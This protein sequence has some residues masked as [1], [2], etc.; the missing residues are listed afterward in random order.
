MHPVYALWPW[1]IIHQRVYRSGQPSFTYDINIRDDRQSNTAEVV[2][3][4][5][6]AATETADSLGETGSWTQ[7]Q[8]FSECQNRLQQAAGESV[9]LWHSWMNNPEAAGCHTDRNT[10]S[11]FVLTLQRRQPSAEVTPALYVTMEILSNWGNALQVGLTEL[12][13]FCPRNKKLYV[14]PHD[15]DIRNTDYPGNLGVLVNGKMKVSVCHLSRE[16]ASCRHKFNLYRKLYQLHS[17][18][19]ELACILTY[20]HS[21]V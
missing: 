14:S 16:S 2:V 19:V 1:R 8:H 7:L 12:Q 21:N 10:C 5:F 18:L 4:V 6:Q 15:L 11:S 9:T 17:D 13:F 3:L 20:L